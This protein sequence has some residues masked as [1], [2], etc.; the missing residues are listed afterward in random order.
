MRT[1]EHESDIAFRWLVGKFNVIFTLSDGKDQ[2]KF[3]L[4]VNGPEK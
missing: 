1:S 2:K 4:S 3:S